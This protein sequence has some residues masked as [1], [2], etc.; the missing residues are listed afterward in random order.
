MC[1]QGSSTIVSSFSS[2]QKQISV[3]SLISMSFAFVNLFSTTFSTSFTES[4]VCQ[5]KDAYIALYLN[6]DLYHTI[7]VDNIMAQT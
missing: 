1:L 3:L 2:I 5:V 4:L 6:Q 7:S